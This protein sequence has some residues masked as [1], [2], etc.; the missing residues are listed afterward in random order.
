MKSSQ[1]IG[2]VAWVLGLVLA[3][4]SEGSALVVTPDAEVLPVDVESDGGDTAVLDTGTEVPDVGPDAADGSD[5]ADTV[6]PLD[7]SD[8]HD[9]VDVADVAGVADVADVAD[10]VIEARCPET[11]CEPGELCQVGVCVCDTT[12][13]S[14]RNDIAPK[15]ATGCGPGCHV[16]NGSIASGSAG[17]NLALAF[18][19]QEL[20]EVRAIQCGDDR[21]RV[22]SGDVAASYLMGKLLG[23]RMCAGVLMPKGRPAWSATDLALVGRWICQG[24]EDN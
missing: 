7:T 24:A 13:V 2:V 23:R 14:Y 15:F 10:E 22:A 18:S 3:G 9:G 11:P 5:S 17:L 21:V 16:Y 6:A 20:V 1:S 4:C 19:H 12:P 8:T